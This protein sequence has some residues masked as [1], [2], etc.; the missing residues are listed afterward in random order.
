M[1]NLLLG[2][3]NI[4]ARRCYFFSPFKNEVTDGQI[5]RMKINQI[6]A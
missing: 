6:M 1:Y 3:S 2:R 5:V 4:E